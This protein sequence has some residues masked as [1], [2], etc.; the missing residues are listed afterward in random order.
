MGWQSAVA[1]VALGVV[2]VGIAVVAVV[3]EE[4]LLAAGL[5]PAVIA[6]ARGGETC[7]R[8]RQNAAAVAVAHGMSNDSDMEDEHTAAAAGGRGAPNGDVTWFIQVRAHVERTPFGR[9]HG[10]HGPD[11]RVSSIFGR[12]RTCTLAGTATG[13]RR[14]LSGSSARP[15]RRSRPRLWS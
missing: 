10:A 12:C 5:A 15:S 6:A 2:L 7:G 8:R 4:R 14:R 9:T 11:P 3:R 13:A 1:V